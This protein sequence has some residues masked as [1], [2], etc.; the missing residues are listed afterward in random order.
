ME[1]LQ[2]KDDSEVYKALDSSGKEMVDNLFPM[3]EHYDYTKND[4]A[5]LVKKMKFDVT[6]VQRAVEHILDTEKPGASG[7]S[8]EWNTVVSKQEKRRL[9]EEERK[10]LEE[11]DRLRR[12]EEA[13]KKKEEEKARR[14]AEKKAWEEEQERVQ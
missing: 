4:I 12:K 5:R 10:K 13:R 9:Q 14:K 7:I 1:I 3:L 8:T 6:A 2:S 11:E